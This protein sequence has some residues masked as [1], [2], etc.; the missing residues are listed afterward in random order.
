MSQSKIIVIF[1]TS[2]QDYVN[3]EETLKIKMKRNNSQYH[4]NLSLTKYVLYINH[5]EL[6]AAVNEEILTNSETS[7]NLNKYFHTHNSLYNSPLGLPSNN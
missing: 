4:L 7:A 2:K 3:S 6:E 5:F 1:E